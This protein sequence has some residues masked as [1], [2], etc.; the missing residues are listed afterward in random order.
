MRR[1][2][3]SFK[4]RDE[5]DDVIAKF[6]GQLLGQERLPLQIRYADTQEQKRF[7]QVTQER[8]DYK[9]G[10]YNTVAYGSSPSLYQLPYNLS[11]SSLHL[12][13]QPFL[14]RSSEIWDASG[15]R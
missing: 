14:R 5:C 8:R 15:H 7:K 12:P 2:P 1:H 10:E 3:C 11:G 4:N 9:S 13:A 6:N